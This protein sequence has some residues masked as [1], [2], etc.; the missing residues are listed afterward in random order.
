MNPP[1]P[2]KASDYEQHHPGYREFTIVNERVSTVPIR[3]IEPNLAHAEA[4]LSFLGD[5]EVGRYTGGDFSKIS[6]QTEEDRLQKILNNDDAYNW[7]IEVNGTVIGNININGIEESSTA[8]Q[9]RSGWI[10]IIIGDK[11][12][13]GKGM[14]RSLVNTVCNWAF[15]EAGFERINAR[16]RVENIRSEKSFTSVGFKKTGAT[17]TETINEKEVVWNHYALTKNEWSK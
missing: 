1:H 3:L 10:A 16:I 13:W 15:H 4:S 14:A 11:N 9:V 8:D 12:L 7:M 6:L 2:P 17:D 5:E